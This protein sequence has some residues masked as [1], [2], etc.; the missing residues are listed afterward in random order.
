MVCARDVCVFAEGITSTVLYIDKFFK[1]SAAQGEH[2]SRRLGSGFASLSE[3]EDLINLFLALGCVACAAMAAGLT[4]GLVSLD[5]MQ[6][7]A[8]VDLDD[9]CRMNSR[10]RSDGNKVPIRY[11]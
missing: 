4:M 7:G 1:Y 8:V 2:V 3:A 5:E 10:A 6:V 9:Q 11:R